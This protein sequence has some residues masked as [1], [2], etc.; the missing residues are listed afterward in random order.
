MEN[1][2]ELKSMLSKKLGSF[3]FVID[4]RSMI[5]S[6]MIWAGQEK[7]ES[8]GKQRFDNFFKL[9]TTIHEGSALMEDQRRAKLLS[10]S[11]SF[12]P[13]IFVCI[14]GQRGIFQSSLLR[15]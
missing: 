4:L 1:F 7:R 5:I 13:H 11:S 15:F 10:C 3:V 8:Y 6:Y 12:I 9:Y 14:F 2:R